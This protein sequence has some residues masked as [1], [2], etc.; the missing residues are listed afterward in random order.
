LR[1]HGQEEEAIPR[2]RLLEALHYMLDRPQLADLVIADLAR[3]Q[4]WAIMDRL[5]ELFKNATDETSWVRVPVINY[6]QACPLPKAKEY[7]VEL[8]KL[9]PESVKKATNLF[10]I[11]GTAPAA[12]GKSTAPADGKPAGGSDPDASK[13]DA[14]QQDAG[15]KDAAKNDA[16]DQKESVAAA[17][18]DSGSTAK[19]DPSTS[20]S[21]PLKNGT[22]SEQHQ[23]DP[24]RKGGRE[25]PVPIF[26]HAATQPGETDAAD[27][28]TARTP[29]SGT[30][31]SRAPAPSHALGTPAIGAPRLLAWMALAGCLLGASFWAIL[32]GGQKAN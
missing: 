23:A 32:G 31:L 12:R 15:K 4:D 24:A 5:V 16:A 21:Q 18:S 30:R 17:D 28:T 3:W 11:G 7:L 10:P 19:N 1:F 6:L 26:Q 22:G 8:A 14:A 29:A 9:D 27:T 25:V 20:A 2:A 13:K